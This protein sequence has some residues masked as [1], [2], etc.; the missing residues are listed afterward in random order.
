MT[1]DKK[2]S[3]TAQHLCLAKTFGTGTSAIKTATF[4]LPETKLEP[5]KSQAP[6]FLPVDTESSTQDCVKQTRKTQGTLI[7][8]RR[9]PEIPNPGHKQFLAE[10]SLKIPFSI[11]TPISPKYPIK[12]A[13]RS[14][15]RPVLS[16]PYSTEGKAYVLVF[17]CPFH[18]W[19][20]S[21]PSCSAVCLIL[22]KVF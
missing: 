1:G 20:I 11:S 18:H 13:W 12:V 17:I 5:W 8:C 19:Q 10:S 6:W 16:I 15:V 4:S 7:D 14:L 22:S 3:H 2:L 21:V 9:Y